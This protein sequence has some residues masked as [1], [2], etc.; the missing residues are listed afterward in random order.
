M[1]L[2]ASF[3]KLFAPPTLVTTFDR[4]VKGEVVIE[5]AV[6]PHAEDGT[7]P[8]PIKS[9]PCVAFFYTASYR[10]PGRQAGLTERPLRTVEVFWPFELELDGGRVEAVPR[11]AGAFTRDDHQ[12]LASAGYAQFQAVEQVVTPRTRVRLW[13]VAK[14][15]ADGWVVT[16]RR[17][18]KLG[19]EKAAAG[20][21]PGK[22]TR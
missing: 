2:L 6:R 22:R 17:I 7:M 12:K 3:K 19:S 16:Y 8:S 5:G 21:K 13:G 10:S 9:Q 20:A 11:V 15:T 1:G 4:L 14:P 18:E